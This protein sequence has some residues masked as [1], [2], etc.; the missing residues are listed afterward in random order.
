LKGR[1]S[2]IEEKDEENEETPSERKFE[3]NKL[4]ETLQKRKDSE[5]EPVADQKRSLKPVKHL[6]I[7]TDV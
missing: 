5:S 6:R 2:K 4:L 3:M 1:P 7:D